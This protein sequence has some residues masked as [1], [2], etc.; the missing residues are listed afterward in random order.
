MLVK[1]VVE[2]CGVDIVEREEISTL[3]RDYKII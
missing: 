1:K 3:L 2:I